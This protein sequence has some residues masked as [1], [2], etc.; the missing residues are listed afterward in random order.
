MATNIEKRRRVRALE[1][2]RDDLK[3]KRDRATAELK[4]VAAELKHERS[5]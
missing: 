2:K 3:L 1:A 4:K 5:K